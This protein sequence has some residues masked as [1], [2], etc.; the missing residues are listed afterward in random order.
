[1][2]ADGGSSPMVK[3]KGDKQV[4]YLDLDLDPGKSTPPRKVGTYW[5]VESDDFSYVKAKM[6]FLCLSWRVMEWAWRRQTSAWTT[7]SWTSNGHRPLRA[8]GRP[9]TTVAS[10]QRRT[11][12]PKDPSDLDVAKANPPSNPIPQSARPTSWSL[13]IR[14]GPVEIQ[15]HS[16][17]FSLHCCSSQDSVTW[18]RV[19]GGVEPGI[20]CMQYESR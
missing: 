14:M 1:M 4:E 11:T 8:P 6:R 15:S 12:L 18:T 3:P 2:T 9:G 10:P 19:G 7:W 16:F 5:H 13:I 20:S 17:V